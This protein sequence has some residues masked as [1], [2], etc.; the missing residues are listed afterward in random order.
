MSRIL[1]ATRMVLFVGCPAAKSLEPATAPTGDPSAQGATKKE[2]GEGA[3]A[4][5]AGKADRREERDD[6]EEPGTAAG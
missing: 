4:A 3:A 5:G 2:E 6:E 1:F